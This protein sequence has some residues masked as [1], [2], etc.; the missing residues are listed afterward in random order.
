VP[1]STRITGGASELLVGFRKKG[2]GR[3]SLTWPESVDEALC[4][5]W[6]DGVRRGLGEDAYAI[7]F[8]PRK[9]RSKWSAVNLR[10]AEEL[11]AEGRMRPAGL[12][13]YERRIEAAYSYERDGAAFSAEQEALFR[14]RPEAWEFWLTQPPGYRRLN[15]FRVVSAKR[16][17]TQLKR[18]DA[19][20]EASARGE[21][22]A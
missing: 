5:G 21:R 9:P 8:T 12:A 10:R 13:A 4:Y 16:A 7:R 1:G 2:S 19:L 18:L 14:A 22:L 11:I 17:E 3:P 20:I 15:T 6:I